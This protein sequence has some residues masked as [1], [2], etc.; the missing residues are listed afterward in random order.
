MES[1]S[2]PCTPPV[3]SL[4]SSANR[5]FRFPGFALGVSDKLPRCEFPAVCKFFHL[6]PRR[7]RT[8]SDVV[9]FWRARCRPMD[10]SLFWTRRGSMWSGPPI[11]VLLLQQRNRVNNRNRRARHGRSTRT[12]FL[13]RTRSGMQPLSFHN[14][15]YFLGIPQNYRGAALSASY[16]MTEQKQLCLVLPFLQFR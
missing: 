4:C 16:L 8:R 14:P 11:D 10:F 6:A 13:W 2:S 9:A 1:F 7:E 12:F 3:A 5:P 15:Y